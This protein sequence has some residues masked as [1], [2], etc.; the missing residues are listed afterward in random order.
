MFRVLARRLVR[1]DSLV[2][3]TRNFAG[4]SESAVVTVSDLG[5]GVAQLTLN[6]PDR[7]NAL[8]VTMGEQFVARAEELTAMARTGE[9]LR[10]FNDSNI[11]EFEFLDRCSIV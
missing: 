11:V 9:V 3:P 6:D 1:T 4:S 7:L 10:I 8:T 2:V 5:D